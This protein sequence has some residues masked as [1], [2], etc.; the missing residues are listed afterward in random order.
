MANT[1]G[2]TDKP[3][4]RE[5]IEEDGRVVAAHLSDVVTDPDS[6]EAV[7]IPDPDQYPSANA[8][9]QNPLAVHQASSPAD[10]L[11]PDEGAG[12]NEVQRVDPTGTVSGGSYD[13]VL[14][15]GTAYETTL[16]DVPFD[17]TPTQV[18]ALIAA[19]DSAKDGEGNVV[20]T[21]SGAAV[22]AGNL[23]FTFQNDLAGEDVPTLTV[24]GSGI[25]GGGSLAAVTV[26]PGQH[27]DAP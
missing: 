22:S 25:T 20:V 11:D 5:V 2:L 14:A 19:Q 17:A 7:Q 10:A 1:R 26:T 27:A 24:D 23:D 8:T 16:T 3:I 18:N 6:P 9:K 4:T 13:V 21:A 12:V 15:P